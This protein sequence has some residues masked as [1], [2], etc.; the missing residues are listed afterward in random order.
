MKKKTF[1]LIEDNI[2]SLKNCPNCDEYY[3][4]GLPYHL[5]GEAQVNGIRPKYTKFECM[6]CN[7]EFVSFENWDELNKNISNERKDI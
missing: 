3:P 1:E 2:N 6:F 5:V 4:D 7:K